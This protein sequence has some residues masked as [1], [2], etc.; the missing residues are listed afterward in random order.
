MKEKLGDTDNVISTHDRQR[1]TRVCHI[2]KLKR[3][4]CDSE[5]VPPP[6][7]VTVLPVEMPAETF[8]VEGGGQAPVP[9]LQNSAVLEGPATKANFDSS[10]VCRVTTRILARTY[11][12]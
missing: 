10:W 8:N 5:S 9:K 11:H 1:K 12:R 6:N 7:P 3:P 4:V 2:K